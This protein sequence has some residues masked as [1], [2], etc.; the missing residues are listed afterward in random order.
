MRYSDDFGGGF[1]RFAGFP[2]KQTARFAK[3]GKPRG[4]P[5]ASLA[6]LFYL[7]NSRLGI[8]SMPTLI[9]GKQTS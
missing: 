2:A 8:T 5:G 3:T 6:F 1:L 4:R 7:K 9:L